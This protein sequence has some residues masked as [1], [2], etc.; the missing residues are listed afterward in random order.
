V[1]LPFKDQK[2]SDILR[3]QFAGLGSVIGRALEPVFKSRKIN[4]FQMKLSIKSELTKWKITNLQSIFRKFIVIKSY[5]FNYFCHFPQKKY[6]NFPKYE[7][8]RAAIGIYDVVL[9]TH[10]ASLGSVSA[11]QLY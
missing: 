6:K 9:S 8:D 11:M 7:N 1:A 4:E 10:N 3:R 5:A 2:S